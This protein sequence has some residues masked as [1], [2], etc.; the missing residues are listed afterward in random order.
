MRNIRSRNTVKDWARLAVKLGVLLTE[1]KTQAA[2]RLRSA[3]GHDPTGGSGPDGFHCAVKSLPHTIE[4][5]KSVPLHRARA[6]A[7]SG[8]RCRKNGRF[9]TTP[10]TLTSKLKTCG[11]A[12]PSKLTTQA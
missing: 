8:R 9:I 3:N 5:Q 10:V 2:I 1:P 7:V 6:G 11:V 4:S 12:K